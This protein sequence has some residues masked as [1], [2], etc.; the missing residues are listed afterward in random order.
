MRI[1]L[2]IVTLGAI[3]LSGIP[4]Q[5]G[6][7]DLAADSPAKKAAREAIL[8]SVEY[9]LPLSAALEG[10]ETEYRFGAL[11]E[12]PLFPEE[13]AVYVFDKAIEA[14]QEEHCGGGHRIE[15]ALPAVP[16]GYTPLQTHAYYAFYRAARQDIADTLEKN[17]ASCFSLPVPGGSADMLYTG[18][19]GSSI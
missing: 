5:A 18:N 15:N 6:M 17:A 19:S 1:F 14:A 8:R 10:L 9:L 16:G 12:I 4:A 2:N 3:A 11:P 7:Y 13:D